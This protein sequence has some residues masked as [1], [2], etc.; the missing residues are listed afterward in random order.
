MMQARA[1]LRADDDGTL[2]CI[3]EH[4]CGDP[5]CDRAGTVILVM[6]PDQPTEVAK[7]DEP[8][9]SV[10]ATDLTAALAPMAGAG[11]LAVPHLVRA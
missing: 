2:V 5:K 3:T 1:I 7:I 11:S 6:R 4:E 8:L 9:D 10:T